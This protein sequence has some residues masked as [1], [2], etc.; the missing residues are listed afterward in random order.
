MA[1]TSILTVSLTDLW[2]LP[3]NNE[4]ISLLRNVSKQKDLLDFNSL[5][6]KILTVSSD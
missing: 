5:I 6:L 4:K 1:D 3:G 2:D